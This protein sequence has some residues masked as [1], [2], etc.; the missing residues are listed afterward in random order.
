MNDSIE[1]AYIALAGRVMCKV[2]GHVDKGDCLVS[3]NNGTAIKA[4]EDT[5]LHPGS[6]FAKSLE[7]GTGLIEV[8]IL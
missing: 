8:V 5:H 2:S 1:G 3:H 6:I 7:S 4:P